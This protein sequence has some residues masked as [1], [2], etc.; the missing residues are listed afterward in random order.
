MRLLLASDPLFHIPVEPLTIGGV[1][2]AAGIDAASDLDLGRHVSCFAPA[3]QP[4]AASLVFV[5]AGLPSNA[6]ALSVCAAVICTATVA[7]GLPV[8]PSAIV[9]SNPRHVF[10]DAALALF[11]G[12][13]GDDIAMSDPSTARTVGGALV[14]GSAR[15]EDGV[16]VQPGAVIGDNVEIGSGS[17]IGAGTTIARNCRIGRNARIGPGVSVQY[18]LIGDRVHVLAGARIGQEGFG[19]VPRADGLRR[20]P[21]LGRVILQDDVEIGANSTVDRGALGDTVIGQGTKIDNLVQI[22]HN[23]VIGTNTV[24]AGS[25]GISGSVTIG[26]LC[27]FGGGVGVADHLTIGDRVT[28]M[29]RS[30]VSSDIG[31]DQ[32]WAGTPATP[33]RQQ[34][35]QMVALRRLADAPKKS[36]HEG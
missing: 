5:E 20:M 14:A 32:V 30:G 3:E 33:A 23:V 22:A 6:G 31:D 34:A 21:Q 19:F 13:L 29:A 35:K 17:V 24:I 2:G 1:F 10:Q 9:A 4:A 26:S 12:S 7:A 36:P 8:G 28:I 15:L 16:V 11:P 18:A 27:R 25:C